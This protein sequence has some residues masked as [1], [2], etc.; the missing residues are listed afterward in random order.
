MFTLE[1]LVH[2]S[3]TRNNLGRNQEKRGKKPNSDFGNNYS[4]FHKDRHHQAKTAFSFF[5]NFN[6][7]GK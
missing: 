2:I 6:L 3:N 7:A 1:N 4:K 5:L